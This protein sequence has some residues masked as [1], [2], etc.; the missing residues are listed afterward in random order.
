MA[1]SACAWP[2][3]VNQQVNLIDN[4]ARRLVR[5]A[6]RSRPALF[7][8][9]LRLQFVR[10]HQVQRLHH[11]R[12]VVPFAGTVFAGV[13]QTERLE[14][15]R[16]H[17]GRPKFNLARVQSQVGVFAGYTSYLVDDVLQIF[18]PAGGDKS[19]RNS[20]CPARWSRWGRS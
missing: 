11:A 7:V 10:V 14:H 4:L 20:V 9:Q 6:K 13:G 16:T 8:S 12:A 18:A 1:L 2:T 17:D 3:A 19:G 5:L 15:R